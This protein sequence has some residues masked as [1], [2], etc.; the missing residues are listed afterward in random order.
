MGHLEDAT[1]TRGDRGAES[2]DYCEQWRGNPS[3]DVHL[4]ARAPD[5]LGE[6]V[7][8]SPFPRYR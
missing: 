7:R 5:L 3:D 2:T 1:T 6:W 4:G 8:R